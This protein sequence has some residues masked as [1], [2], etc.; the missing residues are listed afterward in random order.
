M[1][2]K[3][4]TTLAMIA[5]AMLI[6]L[7]SAMAQTPIWA[8]EFDGTEI[9]RT[10]WTFDVGGHGFGNQELQ[11]YS[12]RTENV[13]VEDGHLVI[14]AKREAY[15]GKEFTSA[16][17]K[18]HGRMAVKY[19]TIEARIRVPDLA[20]GLWPA[21][22]LLGDNIGQVSWPGCGEIDI[23]EMG[24]SEA[25]ATGL[26]NRRVSA[27]GHWD[28]FGDYAGYGAHIDSA[29]NLNDDYH[30]YKLT[31]TPTALRAYLDGNSSHWG[32]DIDDPTGTSMEEFHN[33]AFLVLN[34][35]VG[36][37]NFVD[38]TN[39]AL[40]TAPFPACMYIDW[41]R[42]YDNGATE[43]TVGEDTAEE[44]LFGIYTETT[45]V[46]GSLA[47][48][49]DTE[50]YI[51][52]N[53]TANTTPAYEGSDVMGFDIAAG[54]W[55]GMGVYCLQNRN[56]QNYAN[57]NLHLHMK[58]ASTHTFGIGV[59]SSSAGE[60]W[61]DLVDGE[62]QFGLVR[63]GAWHELIIPLSR[64]S[65]VDFNTIIQMFMFKGE[66]P[67]SNIAVAI[68]NVYWEPSTPLTTP[69]NGNF[70]VFT[71]SVANT[72]AGEFVLGVDGEFFVWE[73]TL[74]AVTGSPYEGSSSIALA[75]APGLAWFGAA[76]TPNHM[77][78]MTAFRYPESKLHF[79]LKTSS[80]V[81]F[82]IGMKG[83][84][85]DHIGQEWITF[86]AGSDPYG[87]LRD[88]Q[89]HVV[90]IPMSDLS[91]V[92]LSRVTQFF[93]ILG[94]DGPISDIEVDDICFLNGGTASQGTGSGSPSADAGPDQTLI[95]PTSST[96]LPGSGSDDDGTIVS[97]QWMQASGPATATMSGATT[98]TLTVS[99]L[100]EGV[101]AFRLTVTDNDGLVGSDMVS[102]TVA[103]PE[104][105]ANAGPDQSVALPT[106]SATLSGSGAD[107]DGTITGYL[108]SQ[109][110]GPSTATM[111]HPTWA[112]TIVSDLVEG[113]YVFTL[114]VTDNDGLTGSDQVTVEVSN[115][116]QNVALGKPTTA[117]SMENAAM[118]PENAVDGSLATRWASA[119][120]D[121][122]WIEIDLQD[123]YDISQVVLTWETAAASEYSIDISDDGISWDSIYFTSAG[124]GGTETLDVSS[125]GRYIR[126][127][128]TAR[129]TVY[130]YSLFEFEV[131]GTPAQA[132][133][134]D[135]D[136]D[137]DVDL[138]DYDEFADCMEGPGISFVVGC[139]VA[140]M[141]D[142]E[143]VDLHDFAEWELLLVGS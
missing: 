92:D 42:I 21:F 3:R 67:A 54:S 77:Y 80:S 105:T 36:G 46:N 120:D 107:V 69:E 135:L 88:G 87:F 6:A 10:K 123:P 89:W 90:E 81:T 18:S 100:V 112:T 55:F 70:G 56:M 97:Y 94:V 41:I 134:G 101:Y 104:P 68:D 23:L 53:M 49:T 99:D 124:T 102:V 73:D 130:G 2:T 45:P 4:N 119:F 125:S 22:W 71:E 78:N 76:F 26:V 47:Y 82:K 58:T 39:P 72:T 20:D 93:E 103:T 111:I 29:V 12:T 40:I 62:E 35:A 95:L 114:T 31:W 137:G 91:G 50:L 1:P 38:I 121:P 142:D 138:D 136:G 65:N 8:D 17:L 32:L 139:E 64:F 5:L 15:E 48:G 108:W 9:D 109:E 74:N 66:S 28:Y 43:L 60:G 98:D 110:S 37:I 75:S 52:N 140:D 143:D 33:P 85:I 27:A 51:W 24:T 117:S 59:A 129:T 131:Y 14:Q 115:P 19:G 63:D 84:T 118:G 96:I 44:G 79:A 61:I 128:G 126:M 13:W 7:P 16:R 122:Q 113:T 57:G 86:E 133:P 30:I 141:D 83:G 116:P 25:I 132:T 106:S 34:L 127:Y 11:F